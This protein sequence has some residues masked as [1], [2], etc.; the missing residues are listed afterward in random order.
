MAGWLFQKGEQSGGPAGHFRSMKGPEL[1]WRAGPGPRP[2]PG[3]ARWDRTRPL[4]WVGLVT[5]ALRAC[6]AEPTPVK[7]R[8][9]ASSEAAA[10]TSPS[11]GAVFESGASVSC[12]STLP[13][14]TPIDPGL[15]GTSCL[16]ELSPPLPA[17]GLISTVLIDGV[18]LPSSEYEVH[19]YDLL[20]LTG[21]A[22]EDYLDGKIANVS[23]NVGCPA[24]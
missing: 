11:E 1:R 18:G 4:L 24:F 22:C 17:L 10:D 12:V 20:E 6:A 15:T 3:A 19:G 5:C 9:D 23:V 14:T 16:F 13:R 7:T 8:A 21:V 2:G